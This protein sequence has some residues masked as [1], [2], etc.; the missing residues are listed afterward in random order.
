MFYILLVNF[1]LLHP[2]HLTVTNIE[3]LPQKKIFIIQVRFFVDDLQEAILRE[4]G[5][6][7]V[8][9]NNKNKQ[10]K[11]LLNRYIRNNLKIVVDGYDLSK[12]YI[13]D[14]YV[15]EDITLWLYM[16]AKYK[17]TH[18]KS[19]EIIN[20]LITNLYP[21]QQNLLIFVYKNQEKGLTFN[22][23]KKQILLTY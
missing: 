6:K 21:D 2:V 17:N 10:D 9:K 13:I 15:L 23:K 22:S 12:N 4:T 16:H 19:V 3:F 8:F 7:I 14:K 18:F 5:Q 20:S 1:L 11:E